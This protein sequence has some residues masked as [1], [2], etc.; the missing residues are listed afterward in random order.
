MADDYAAKPQVELEGSLLPH[1]IDLRLEQTVVDDHLF[2]PDMF[3]L[4][5]RDP[6]QNVL[7][8]AG[9]KIGSRVTILAAPLGYEA[10]DQLIMGEVT[11][12]EAEFDATGSHAVVRG[13]DHSHRLHRGRK[14]RSWQQATDSDVARQ[15]ARQAQ[16]ELG[17][18][19]QTPIVHEHIAQAN[20]TDW[21]FLHARAREVG[22]EVAVVDGKLDFRKPA[23]ADQAPG[24]G[25]LTS[26]GPRQLI[27]GKTLDSFRPRLSSAEQVKEVE[28]RGWD[29]GVKKAVVGH[30]PAGTM[31]A[32]LELAPAELAAPFGDPTYVSV[33]RPFSTQAEVDAAAAALAEQIGGASA[34]AEAVAHGNPELHAGAPVSIGLAGHPFEGRYTISGSRHVFGPDGYK[35]HFVVSGRQERSLLGLA[36]LGATNAGAAGSPPIYGVV[37]GQV[38]DVRD[39]LDQGRVRLTFPWLSDSYTSDW[40]RVVQAGAGHE[41]GF[42]I[43]PE[44]DDEVLVAF[45]HGDVEYPHV[46]GGLHNGVDR[47][48]SL[49]TLVDSGTGAVDFRWFASRLGHHI[50]FDDC[51]D[52]GGILLRTGDENE[53]IALN[54]AKQRIRITSSG[55]IVIEGEGDITIRSSGSLSLGASSSLELKAPQVSVTADAQLTLRGGMVAIN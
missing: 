33:E 20:L 29:P 43:V 19:D 8:R 12:L 42:V 6:E 9:F 46:I 13:Y 16:L 50:S 15:V 28:V 11:A 4:R 17:R 24:A 53:A 55:E 27:L 41:R 7:S 1:E 47:P 22:Y 10:R 21:E 18:I 52:G 49:G 35:T 25:D 38:T 31:S 51:V 40:A 34:E 39:P 14:T 45:Q 26:T 54:A 36:S 44:V 32:A 30:A 2:L 48:K 37:V 5:F 3:M 23:D